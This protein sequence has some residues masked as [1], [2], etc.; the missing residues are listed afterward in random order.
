MMTRDL[1]TANAWSDLAAA[2]PWS[3]LT[4]IH[5][6]AKEVAA[7]RSITRSHFLGRSIT[8]SDFLS[9]LIEHFERTCA[10]IC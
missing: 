2:N 1:A 3:Y 10:H 9:S 8:Q 5:Y 4:A 6:S 7:G